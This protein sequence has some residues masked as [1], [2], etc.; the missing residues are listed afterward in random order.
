MHRIYSA[1]FCI[2]KTLPSLFLSLF[3]P[4]ILIGLHFS[5]DSLPFSINQAPRSLSLLIRE[6]SGRLEIQV[7]SGA[8]GAKTVGNISRERRYFEEK[9]GSGPDLFDRDLWLFDRFSFVPPFDSLRLSAANSRFLYIYFLRVYETWK[10]PC[11][12]RVHTFAKNVKSRDQLQTLRLRPSP[13]FFCSH[14]NPTDPTSSA[15]PSLGKMHVARTRRI[16]TNA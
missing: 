16:A 2:R 11:D 15:I 14:C 4:L 5:R 7:S 9:Y 12:I 8:N 13:R 6:T 1:D 10:I 3:L